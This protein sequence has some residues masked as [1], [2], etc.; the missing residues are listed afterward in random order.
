MFGMGVACDIHWS[1]TASATTNNRPKSQYCSSNSDSNSHTAYNTTENPTPCGDMLHTFFDFSNRNPKIRNI[2][3][4]F[5]G[6][7][8]NL[9]KSVLNKFRI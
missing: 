7:S 5:L 8:F 1:L 9:I 3:F 6:R 2:L 4:D